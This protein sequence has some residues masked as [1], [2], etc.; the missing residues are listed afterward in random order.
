MLETIG[1]HDY[2]S[3][4]IASD[5]WRVFEPVE[6]CKLFH[7]KHEAKRTLTLLYTQVMS[8]SLVLRC[9]DRDNNGLLSRPWPPSPC[10]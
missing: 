2:S 10:S 5:C 4:V 1:V 6:S 7:A 8:E 9:P 3:T